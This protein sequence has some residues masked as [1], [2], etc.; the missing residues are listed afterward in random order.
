M[1]DPDLRRWASQPLS[2]SQS[3]LALPFCQE[4]QLRSGQNRD[5]SRTKVRLW[6]EPVDLHQFAGSYLLEYGSVAQTTADDGDRAGRPDLP[7]EAGRGRTEEDT[8]RG[9]RLPVAEV[10]HRDRF[11]AALR[12][13][14][15]GD[16]KVDFVAPGAGRPL[17]WKRLP[18]R[19]RRPG[20]VELGL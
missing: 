7:G 10:A 16:G 2:W 3:T 11:L 9:A 4:G 13:H 18:D 1:S 8:E 15:N 19:R 6:P 20:V 12:L 14:P 5:P 17:D